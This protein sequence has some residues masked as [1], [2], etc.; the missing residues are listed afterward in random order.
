MSK[1]QWGLVCVFL[2]FCSAVHA[3]QRLNPSPNFLGV[4]GLNTVPNA[5]MEDVG[6][7]RISV[8]AADPYF[9]TQLGFQ[10]NDRL[11]LGLRQTGET[12]SLKN[13]AE[14]LYPGLDLKFKLIDEKSWRPEM[15]IGLQSALGHQ[16]MAAE[17]LVFSKRYE[18]WDLTGGLGWGRL[19]QRQTIPNP[20]LIDH[21]RD[22][23]RTNDGEKPNSPR[24]WFNGDPGLF[25][26]VEYQLPWQ[27][28]SIKA[29]W[30]SEDYDAER[31][32]DNGFG[33]RK[34]FAVSLNYTPDRNF[35]AGIGFL[36][37]DAVLARMSLKTN[38]KKWP[39]QDSQLSLLPPVWPGRAAAFNEMPAEQSLY[40]LKIQNIKYSA[41]S[42]TAEIHLDPFQSMPRELS[43]G[44]R[45]MAN[46]SNQGTE[47]LSLTPI[48]LGLV[49][50][51]AT[52]NRR[53]LEKLEQGKGSAEEIWR[54]LSFKKGAGD[55]SH[56]AYDSHIAYTLKEEISPSEEDNGILHRTGLIATGTQQFLTNFVA[57]SAFRLTLFHNLNKLHELRP[58]AEDPVRSD[59][60]NY[61]SRPFSA[62]RAFFK[63]FKTLGQDLHGSFTAGYLEEMF[64]GLQTEVL[65][66]PWGKKWA[67]GGEAAHLRKRDYLTTF[68]LG[69]MDSSYNTILAHAYYE[70]PDTDLTF[71]LDAGRYLAG[72]YGGGASLQNKFQNGATLKAFITATNQTD[73]DI[74]GDDT[75]MYT[76]LRFT[77][78]LGSLN[79]V[80]DGSSIDVIAAPFGRDA[81]QKP[82][83][84]LP[85]YETTEKLSY[86]HLAAHWGDIVR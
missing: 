35:D 18:N 24:D 50:E 59:I 58:I 68:N 44:W 40:G 37:T 80:P 36:G 52:L 32:A 85:L 2:L 12:N 77:L 61:T 73:P 7:A 78:P 3:E 57:Q 15:A 67:I 71:S 53:D 11:Y 4:V 65:Y 82:D 19:G 72:D 46:R 54:N 64:A 42:E 31:T 48:Y 43:A 55:I 83:T 5:R 27:D 45:V 16:R 30:T 75:N 74:Y 56:N 86:R 38:F 62:E 21:F 8:A 63:G 17:Y 13:E 10:I 25:A 26:G 79:N 20:L 69:L 47:S 60:D 23:N 70:I 84:P 22:N 81:G 14:H 9:H 41:G 76:G 39:L 28:L 1:I 33:S 51:N 29:D 66:R 6:T 34:P 49:G